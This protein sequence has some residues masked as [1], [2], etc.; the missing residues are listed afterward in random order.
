MAAWETAECLLEVWRPSYIPVMTKFGIQ[1]RI[2][3]LYKDFV[4]HHHR[5]KENEGV[6]KF[7]ES[8]KLRFIIAANDAEAQISAD[9]TLSSNEKEED[10]KFLKRVRENLPASLGPLDI[11]RVKR[12]E[13]SSERAGLALERAL[14]EEERKKVK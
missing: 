9:K 4:K 11:K 8:L 5:K 2:L 13:K 3:S 7:R 6:T 1:C 14:K 12:L 10:T